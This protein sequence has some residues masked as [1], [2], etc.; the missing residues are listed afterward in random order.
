MSIHSRC[1]RC[2]RKILSGNKCNCVKR[3][4]DRQYNKTRRDK[5]VIAFYHTVS[6]NRAR[7][8]TIDNCCGL[9]LLSLIRDKRIEYGETVH[10]IIPLKE[11]WDK[12]LSQDNIIYLTEANHQFIHKEMQRNREETIKTLQQIKSEWNT[13]GYMKMFMEGYSST[14]LDL[15]FPQNAL[16]FEKRR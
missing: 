2:G 7:Q 10:H 11:S 4:R 8:V 6:W 15:F 14:P 1:S 9:D 12:R 16:Y 13:G 3:I 5:D